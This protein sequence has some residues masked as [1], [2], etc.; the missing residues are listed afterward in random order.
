MTHT[1]LLE[2]LSWCESLSTSRSCLGRK[3]GTSL[4]AFMLTPTTLCYRR[5]SRSGQYPWLGTFYR[6]TFRLSFKSTTT[7]S[8][9]LRNSGKVPLP[10][11]HFFLTTPKDKNVDIH[12][13]KRKL[14][15]IEEE[16]EK[17]VRMAHLAIVGS[18]HVNGVAEIHSELLKTDLF[19]EFTAV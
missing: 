8:S 12:W 17:K 10:F 19:P 5:P 4:V 2:L 14:S 15:L 3:P 18:H 6:D 16:H 7:S 11:S 13:I 9:K 1:L